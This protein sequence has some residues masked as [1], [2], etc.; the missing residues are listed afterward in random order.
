MV[1]D[2]DTTI[3]LFLALQDKGIDTGLNV[4]KI[5]EDLLARMMEPLD[6]PK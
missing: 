6:R 1:A 4:R 2:E 3:G 5:P